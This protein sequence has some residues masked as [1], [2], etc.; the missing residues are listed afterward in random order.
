VI[1]KHKAP[2]VKNSSR[3]SFSSKA[4]FWLCAHWHCKHWH[5]QYWQEGARAR[6][7]PAPRPRASRLD[8]ETAVLLF[9]GMHA[10]KSNESP[11]LLVKLSPYITAPSYCPLLSGAGYWEGHAGVKLCPGQSIREVGHSRKNAAP[12]VIFGWWATLATLCCPE[13]NPPVP[14]PPPQ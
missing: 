14:N 8:F 6:A 7:A 13:S 11:E 2:A 3:S 1:T 4:R 5:W 9:L 10:R 12:C